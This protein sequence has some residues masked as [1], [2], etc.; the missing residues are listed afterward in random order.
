MDHIL[1]RKPRLLATCG[2]A[3]LAL[4]SLSWASGASAQAIQATPAVV[5]GSV[6]FI[7]AVPNQDTITV[8]GLNA[9]VDWTPLQDLAGNALT[10]LPSTGTVT[11]QSDLSGQNFAIINRILPSTNGN[12]AVIDGRV[13][14]QLQQVSGPSIPGGNVLFYSSTGLLIGQ[15]AQFDISGLVLTTLAPDITSFSAFTGGTSALVLDGAAAVSATVQIDAG[16]RIT[17]P[18]EDSYFAVVAP[19]IRYAGTSDINGSIAYVAGEQV[20]LT[21]SSGLF[22]IFVFAGSTYKTPITHTGASGGPASLGGTDSHVIYGVARGDVDPI[23]ILFG[24]NLGFDPAA[25]ATIENGVIVLAA[26]YN[27]SGT[28]VQNDQTQFAVTGQSQAALSINNA[29]VTS[30]LIAHSS[31]R[32]SVTGSSFLSDFAGDLF[33]YGREA[34]GVTALGTS[35][36]IHIAGAATI[37]ANDVGASGAFLNVPAAMDAAAGLAGFTV[38]DGGRVTVDGNTIVTAVGTLG[39][40][41]GNLTAGSARGGTVEVNSNGGTIT[42]SGTLGMNANGLPSSSPLL[43]NSGGSATGGS[44]LMRAQANGTITVGGASVIQAQGLAMNMLGPGTSQPVG[45][46]Q[47]G[48]VDISAVTTGQIN[49]NNSLDPDK[50]RVV[51]SL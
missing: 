38:L 42:L 10:F 14:S 45:T 40:D 49:F 4:G 50:Q 29:T 13:I 15:N 20:S 43:F 3:A 2:G 47:G 25:S 30:D 9:V 27:V 41:S 21:H 51:R 37:S 11:F 34:A 23:D 18:S 6:T 16:A 22:D 5:Q 24:G 1:T 35:G 19:Q 36:S 46:G 17:G 31:N 28:Q 33:L 12:V 39:V 48:G 32:A 44:A 8:T 7:S 26:N